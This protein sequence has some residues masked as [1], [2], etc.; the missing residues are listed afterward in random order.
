MC[1]VIF[2]K[3]IYI[4]ILIPLFVLLTV[5]ICLKHPL[6]R[7]MFTNIE[8][9]E[10]IEYNGDFT[11]TNCVVKITCNNYEGVSLYFN[12]R[13]IS[14]FKTENLAVTINC[15][16]VFEIKNDSNHL[17]EVAVFCDNINIVKEVYNTGFEQGIKPLCRVKP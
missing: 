16:G 4:A 3:R 8:L 12:G 17:A 11:E 9:Y 2:I 10:N 7:E 6:T 1:G 15:E 14:D 5:Q 13:K